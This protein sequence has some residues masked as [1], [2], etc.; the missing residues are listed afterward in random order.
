M[1]HLSMTDHIVPIVFACKLLISLS[2]MA[3]IVKSIMREN[4]KFHFHKFLANGLVRYRCGHYRCLANIKVDPNNNNAIVEERL[5]HRHVRPRDCPIPSSSHHQESVVDLEMADNTRKNSLD[6]VDSGSRVDHNLDSASSP[7][8]QAEIESDN[9]TNV[10]QDE[11]ADSRTSK[12]NSNDDSAGEKSPKMDEDGGEACSDDDVDDDEDEEEEETTSSNSEDE[13]IPTSDTERYIR[14]R[15]RSA[16]R[17]FI[18]R[19]CQGVS[20]TG[21]ASPLFGCRSAAPTTD[22]WRSKIIEDKKRLVRVTNRLREKY[23]KF[24][25]G[26]ADYEARME[27]QFKPLLKAMFTRRVG[28]SQRGSSIRVT[29]SSFKLFVH[30]RCYIWSQG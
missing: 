6:C 1:L 13:C 23:K 15:V 12:E 4:E 7:R 16:E 2:A 30:R 11:D 18:K 17:R 20:G 29:R 28:G 22:D 19:L 26:E 8:D 10:D 24:R 3:N 14:K 27:R 21:V 5:N 9:C 25:L